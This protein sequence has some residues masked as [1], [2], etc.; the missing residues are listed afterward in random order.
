MTNTKKSEKPFDCLKFK[1]RAQA[2]I[3]E[4]IKSLTP[5]EEIE[6]FRHESET[7]PFAGFIKAI[8]AGKTATLDG[9]D[10]VSVARSIRP[11]GS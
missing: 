7:G 8:D 3:Y 10:A 2:G 1:A 9:A 5:A 6:F 4:K 11:R